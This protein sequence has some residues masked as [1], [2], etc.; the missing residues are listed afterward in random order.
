MFVVFFGLFVVRCSWCSSFV[1]FV[2]CSLFVMFVWNAARKQTSPLYHRHAQQRGT[3]VLRS[4]VKGTE[5]ALRTGPGYPTRLDHHT[6]MTNRKRANC[7]RFS[8]NRCT[9]VKIG[10][11]NALPFGTRIFENCHCFLAQQMSSKS[12]SISCFFVVQQI[13]VK[14]STKHAF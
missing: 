8:V 5:L 9:F 4:S 11:T 14:T 2:R 13:D 6:G 3:S 10:Q 12:M 7:S 1:G